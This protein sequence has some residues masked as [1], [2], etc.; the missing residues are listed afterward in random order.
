M[1]ET[2]PDGPDKK[3]TRLAIGVEGGFFP[4]LNK[5]RFEFVDTRSIFLFPSKI[6]CPWP[7]DNLPEIVSLKIFFVFVNGLKLLILIFR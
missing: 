1:P 5:R 6:S 4:D 3:I 7:D 2:A